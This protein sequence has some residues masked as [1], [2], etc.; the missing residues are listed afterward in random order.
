MV[1]NSVPTLSGFE[2]SFT[3]DENSV[4]AAPQLID[5]DVTFLDPDNNFDGGTLTLSGLLAEDIVSI[6]DQGAGV[7]LI[8]F[9]SDTG[10]V[11]FGGTQIG[12]AS[13]GVG[14]ALTVTFNAAA[15]AAAIEALIE[16]LTYE[17]ASDQQWR[18]RG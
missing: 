1:T 10:A 17:N 13:G 18:R 12:T 3:L 15:T 11:S 5:A 2:T 6:R 9:D 14:S 16:N 7:G 8:Q 4:N